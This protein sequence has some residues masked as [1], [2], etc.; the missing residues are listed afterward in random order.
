[1]CISCSRRITE[2]HSWRIMHGNDSKRLEFKPNISFKWTIFLSNQDMCSMWM[3]DERRF[4]LRRWRWFSD[5]FLSMNDSGVFCTAWPLAWPLEDHLQQHQLPWVS[6]RIIFPS[7]FFQRC[8]CKCGRK[9]A[10]STEMA[11]GQE[12][13]GKD[14]GWLY[15]CV[16]PESSENSPPW[17]HLNS[18]PCSCLSKAD[19]QCCL[20]S[21][22]AHQTALMDWAKC[23]RAIYFFL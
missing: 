17:N 1:M 13:E 19:P 23:V 3:Y 4:K 22:K 2:N 18:E 10:D 16:Q 6:P 5:D 12:E 20:G 11:K 9:W 8:L 7:L 14:A 21:R 15:S